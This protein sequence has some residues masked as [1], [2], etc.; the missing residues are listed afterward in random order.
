MRFV[1]F[2]FQKK[3]FVIVVSLRTRY[4]R[5][6]VFT[7]LCYLETLDLLGLKSLKLGHV[8]LVNAESVLTA[9]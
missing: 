6:A 5:E 2:L 9:P 4:R 1:T 3:P 7:C 8:D